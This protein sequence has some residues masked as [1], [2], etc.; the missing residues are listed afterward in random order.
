MI[1]LLYLLV[2]Y[3]LIFIAVC[4]SMAA[5]EGREADAAGDEE[6][7]GQDEGVAAREALEVGV[8]NLAWDPQDPFLEFN[9]E[10]SGTTQTSVAAL[11]PVS[12]PAKE[13]MP[14]LEGPDLEEP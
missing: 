8:A 5:M 9:N 4:N 11:T 2:R 12:M 1:G 10:N 13:N 6:G 3:E 14:D 7:E